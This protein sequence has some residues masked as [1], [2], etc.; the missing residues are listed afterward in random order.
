MML[1]RTATIKNTAATIII[2]LSQRIDDRFN[3]NSK[4]WKFCLGSFFQWLRWA[5]NSLFSAYEGNAKHCFLDSNSKTVHKNSALLLS[6]TNLLCRT[7][8]SCPQVF[9]KKRVLK[10]FAKFTGQNLCWSLF[11]E[12]IA[13]LTPA[14]LLK[15]RLQ[16]R[17][18]P[19]SFVKFLRTTFL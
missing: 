9:C 5:V 15:R 6:K 12:K 7:T 19:V 10:N 16:H 8:R 11:V 3:V 4:P 2:K 17:C 14:N 18:Y 1:S 13:G